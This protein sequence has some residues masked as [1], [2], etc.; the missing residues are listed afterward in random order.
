[1]MAHHHVQVEGRLRVPVIRHA[2]P[3]TPLHHHLRT[4]A[5][6]Y[7]TPYNVLHQIPAVSIPQ[8]LVMYGQSDGDILIPSPFRLILIITKFWYLF[9]S[10]VLMA[11][12]YGLRGS[13]FQV[14]S[15]RFCEYSTRSCTLADIAEFWG[16]RSTAVRSRWL[17]AN[18]S[19]ASM[20]LM[21]PFVTV[22]TI[23]LNRVR[24]IRKLSG[25][26]TGFRSLFPNTF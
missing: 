23:V 20:A 24:V 22:V 19:I 5:R 11:Y 9:H 4:L 10:G 26:R 13:G 1:M 25:V 7:R 18:R 16:F 21:V 15:I 2:L 14:H 12:G 3:T 6:R 17:W 8:F